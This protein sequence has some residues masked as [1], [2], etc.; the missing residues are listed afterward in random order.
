MS[1]RLK[2]LS[3][4]TTAFI[5]GFKIESCRSWK[6]V[7]MRVKLLSSATTAFISGLKLKHADHGNACQ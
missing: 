2:L 1:V 7:S 6:C 3:S 5:S 4:A